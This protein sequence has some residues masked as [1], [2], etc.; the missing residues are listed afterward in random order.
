M[1]DAA[2]A[3]VAV[4]HSVNAGQRVWYSKVRARF[5]VLAVLGIQPTNMPASNDRY[6]FFDALDAEISSA[7]LTASHY[8]LAYLKKRSLVPLNVDGIRAI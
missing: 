8:A 1:P 5:D 6:F 3:R 4:D 7:S 2:R